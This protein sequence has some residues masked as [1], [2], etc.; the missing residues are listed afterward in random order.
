MY[1]A[2]VRYGTGGGLP[3]FLVIQRWLLLSVG[4][5][6]LTMRLVPFAAG[7]M[8][9]VVFACVARCLLRGHI[10]FFCTVLMACSDKFIWQ[11]A[12][13]KQYSGDVLMS[14]IVL[15]LGLWAMRRE[16]PLRDMA[17]GL[18]GA[19]GLWF[20]HAVIIVFAGVSFVHLLRAAE[21]DAA[22]RLVR[23][24]ECPVHGLVHR[25]VFR[26]NSPAESG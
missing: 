9:L 10:A 1:F 7:V 23:H 8:G 19:A 14:L 24:V 17:L 18:V 12:A 16:R 26:F 4:R 25:A 6:D 22:P 5:D 3:L 2:P 21:R 11:S 20:S 15:A 13:V